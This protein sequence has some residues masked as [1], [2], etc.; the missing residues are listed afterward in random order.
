MM[1]QDFCQTKY[2]KGES[3]MLKM[4]ITSSAIVIGLL[5]TSAASA[6]SDH[7]QVYRAGSAMGIIESVESNVRVYR[8][9]G[10]Y[11]PAA[12]EIKASVRDTAPTEVVAAGSKV[13]FIDQ[14][15]KRLTLCRLRKTTQV[16]GYSI[17]CQ[18]RSLP[19]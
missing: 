11:V 1:L 2:K 12:G 8:G 7:V 17:T 18:A 15:A 4:V 14:D 6:E 5:G 16:N 19:N 3:I 10:D 9:A 13:W